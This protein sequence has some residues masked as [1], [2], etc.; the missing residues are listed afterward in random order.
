VQPQVERDGYRFIMKIGKP[1]DEAKAGTSFGKQ[2]GFRCLMSHSPM[3]F[4]YVRAEAMAGR[5]G[6]KLMAVVAEG[7]E[8]P[9]VP[10]A[11]ARNGSDCGRS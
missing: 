2:K 5:M 9:R 11:D 8:W 1:P 3:N 6:Q 7:K 4:D 10:L